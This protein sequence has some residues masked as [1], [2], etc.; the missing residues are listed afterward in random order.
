ML[1]A[2][3]KHWPEY[4]MEAAG[5]GIFMVSACIVGGILDYPPS[6]IRQAIPDPVVRRVLGGIAMGLTAI[7]IVYSPWGKQSGAHLNPSFTL[8]F[9]RLGKVEAKDTFFYVVSQFVGGLAGVFLCAAV[10]GS[11]IRHPS[12]NYVVTVPGVQGPSVAFG[13]E[14]LISF[15]LMSVVLRVSNH[16]RLARFTGLFA[17]TLVATYIS[18]E[19]PFSGM[20]MNP[21]RTL[22]SALPAQL[23]TGLWIYFTAPPLGMLLAAEVYLR[24]KGMIHC[25]KLHHQNNKRCIFCEY[26]RGKEAWKSPATAFKATVGILRG[27]GMAIRR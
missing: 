25:A 3:R 2:L 19:S 22:A 15:L 7:S 13:A 24:S 23:W 18:V 6:P 17:G 5:L 9:F 27:K 11:P 21:A 16:P 12:V 10:I 20:S 14:L 4:L 1:T 26:Q 8:T